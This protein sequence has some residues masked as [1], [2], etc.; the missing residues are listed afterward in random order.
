MA[1]GNP[2]QEAYDALDGF[3]TFGDMLD[4]AER[5]PV[6]LHAAM[7]VERPV[8]TFIEPVL[9]EFADCF[10]ERLPDDLPQERAVEFELHMKPNARPSSRAPFRLSRTEQGSLSLFVSELLAKG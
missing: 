2:V 6:V 8:P 4:A 10:P 9:T 7:A 5:E 3:L 1:P